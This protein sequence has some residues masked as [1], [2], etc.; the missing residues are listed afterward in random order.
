MALTSK[1]ELFGVKVLFI[2]SQTLNE[3]NLLKILGFFNQKHQRSIFKK[4]IVLFL[5]DVFVRKSLKV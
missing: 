4:I 3:K 2:E 5:K 1:K